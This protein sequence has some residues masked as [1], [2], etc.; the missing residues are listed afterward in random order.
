MSI[1]DFFVFLFLGGGFSPNDVIPFVET[2]V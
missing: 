1:A 2:E